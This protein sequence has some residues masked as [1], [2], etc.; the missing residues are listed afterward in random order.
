MNV[1]YT[2]KFGR[3][4]LDNVIYKNT[5]NYCKKHNLPLYT[6]TSLSSSR[7]NKFAKDKPVYQNL[8]FFDMIKDFVAKAKKDTD[9]AAFIGP[10]AFPTQEAPNVFLH[11]N[12]C[13]SPKRS[14]RREAAEILRSKFSTVL[15]IDAEIFSSD[16]AVLTKATA[17]E[18]HKTIQAHRIPDRFMG[19]VHSS[20]AASLIS[21]LVSF[22]LMGNEIVGLNEQFSVPHIELGKMDYPYF[23]IFNRNLK[24]AK[25]LVLN[26]GVSG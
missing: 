20:S 16:V 7:A 17:K 18:V 10:N 1:V 9:K 23:I 14:I 15:E 4:K 19:T 11:K 5:E 25:E 3:E 24:T 13:T 12:S 6:L 2:A 8:A 26:Y 21:S 22:S